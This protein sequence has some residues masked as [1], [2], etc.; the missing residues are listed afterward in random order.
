MKGL[1]VRASPLGYGMLDDVL[2]WLHNPNVGRI[3]AQSIGFVI[4]N[5]TSYAVFTKGAYAKTNVNDSA[6]YTRS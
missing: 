5:D 6:F 4:S 1:I 3:A 2:M